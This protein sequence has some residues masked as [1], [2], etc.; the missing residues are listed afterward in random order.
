[1]IKKRKVIY[2]KALTPLIVGQP[3]IV[4]PLNHPSDLVVNGHQ[5]YTT[6]I[7][8][9]APNGTTFS[10]R[11]TLYVLIGEPDENKRVEEKKELV[12]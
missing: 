5:C 12:A 3:A 2:I 9:I 11:N 4:I 7:Q 1:M 8:T 10:T 6:P